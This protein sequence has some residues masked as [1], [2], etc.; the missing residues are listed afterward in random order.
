[1]DTKV[2]KE[3][4]LSYLEENSLSYLEEN[5]LM[6]LPLLILLRTMRS[7]VPQLVTIVTSDFTQIPPKISFLLAL[8]NKI[9]ILLSS[10]FLLSTVM[11]SLLDLLLSE[12]I[13]QS[14]LIWKMLS[15]HHTLHEDF[16]FL[17]EAFQG[18]PHQL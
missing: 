11:I 8:C 7:K 18:Y 3:N 6:F 5:Y 12:I 10:I 2:T 16:P 14:A 15:T 4:S 1:L 13:P 9:N 17:G